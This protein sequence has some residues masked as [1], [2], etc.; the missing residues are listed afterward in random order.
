MGTCGGAVQG[1][2]SRCGVNVPICNVCRGPAIP[3]YHWDVIRC[4]EC[5]EKYLRWLESQRKSRIQTIES[6]RAAQ[7]CNRGTIS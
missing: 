6:A 4:T 1:D 3:F 7:H 2:V 5:A